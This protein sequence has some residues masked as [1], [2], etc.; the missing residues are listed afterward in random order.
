MTIM[1]EDVLIKSSG[2]AFLLFY[3]A[4]LFCEKTDMALLLW[5]NLVH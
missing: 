5:L 2:Y 3:W 1:T 4:L